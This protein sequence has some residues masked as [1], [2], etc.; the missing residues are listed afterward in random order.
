MKKIVDI[1]RSRGEHWVGNGFPVRSL[2]SYQDDAEAISPFLLFDYAGPHYFEPNDGAPRGVGQH[3]HRGFET[4]TIVY[5]GEVSH[6]DSTDWPRRCA[7]DDGGG[8]RYP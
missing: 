4:V 2:F 8:W 3:P 7:V 1:L 5:D 6:A